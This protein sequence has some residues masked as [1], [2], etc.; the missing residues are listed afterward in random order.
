M[1]FSKLVIPTNFF[2]RS[3]HKNACPILRRTSGIPRKSIRNWLYSLFLNLKMH[4][5]EKTACFFFIK[6]SVSYEVRQEKNVEANSY[7]TRTSTS[8]YMFVWWLYAFVLKYECTYTVLKISWPN[9][10]LYEKKQGVKT[11]W[12]FIGFRLA[13]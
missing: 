1:I 7:V 9:R 8:A 12:F 6:L 4:F 3:C 11:A 2:Y 5:V 13:G 10:G